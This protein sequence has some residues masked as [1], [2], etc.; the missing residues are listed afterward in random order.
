[1]EIAASV[2]IIVLVVVLA[3]ILLFRPLV[4]SIADRIAG[5]RPGAKEI[6]ALHERVAMLEGEINDMRTKY[7]ALEDSQEFSRKLLEDMHSH[8]DLEVKLEEAEEPS[9]MIEMDKSEE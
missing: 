3:P 5:K 9:K 8:N 4:N 1:M 2:V 6:E 7:A